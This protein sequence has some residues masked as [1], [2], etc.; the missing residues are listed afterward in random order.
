MKEKR[1]MKRGSATSRMIVTAFIAISMAVIISGCAKSIEKADVIKEFNS[2]KDVFYSIAAY[3][4][5]T[6]DIL[7]NIDKDAGNNY[8]VGDAKDADSIT[9][10]KD[11]I[12]ANNLDVTFK[13]LFTIGYETVLND[14]NGV[15]FIRVAETHFESGVVFSTDGELPA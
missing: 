4:G 5:S 11:Q 12:K 14:T 8:I 2:N 3:M 9:A 10:I 6:H 13:S 1:D 15:F 7:L